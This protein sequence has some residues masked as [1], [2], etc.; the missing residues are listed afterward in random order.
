[1]WIRTRHSN[2]NKLPSAARTQQTSAVCAEFHARTEVPCRTE[3]ARCRWAQICIC[4]LLISVFANVKCV[5]PSCWLRLFAV[6]VLSAAFGV[7]LKLDLNLF[8]FWKWN[9][10]VQLG[11]NTAKV[12]EDGW[13]W[14]FMC[15]VCYLCCM[16]RRVGK[17]LER[18]KG[19]FR[20][21][22]PAGRWRCIVFKSLKCF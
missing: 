17:R 19:S 7:I 2:E 22:D 13:N 4:L 6:V 14:S 16:G 5:M 10:S 15:T 11:G 8:I 12:V 21:M 9:L 3:F 18:T 1:M 20:C